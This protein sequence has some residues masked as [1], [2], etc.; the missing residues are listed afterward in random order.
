MKGTAL[1]ELVHGDLVVPRL[2]ATV[3]G[4]RVAAQGDERLP[5]LAGAHKVGTPVDRDL[6]ELTRGG[7][8]NPEHPSQPFDLGVSLAQVVHRRRNVRLVAQMIETALES[9]LCLDRALLLRRQRNEGL[10]E[11]GLEEVLATLT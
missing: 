10:P 11:L 2:F 4:V 6:L 8:L 3:L 1:G 5:L 7:A 9:L